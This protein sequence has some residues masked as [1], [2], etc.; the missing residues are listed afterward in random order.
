MRFCSTQHR[1][2]CGRPARQADV[3][4]RAGHGR[5]GSRPPQWPRHPGA[6]SDHHRGVPGGHRGGRR[7][8]LHLRPGGGPLRPGARPVHEGDPRGQGQERQDRCAQARRAAARGHAADGLCRPSSPTRT[9]SPRPSPSWPTSWPGRSTLCSAASTPSMRRSSSDC[10]WTGS[11]L[12]C[13]PRSNPSPRLVGRATCPLAMAAERGRGERESLPSN[14]TLRSG[15]E[16]TLMRQLTLRHRPPAR[17][18]AAKVPESWPLDWT[19]VPARRS[20]RRHVRPRAVGCPS[21]EPGANWDW[22][23]ARARPR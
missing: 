16:P 11:E 12:G 4:L 14:W 17:I 10:P 15:T 22:S 19:P 5:Q 1:Y 9:A 21:P 23:H 13:A 8:H 3:H 7:V 6:L 20:S 2:Y 18:W